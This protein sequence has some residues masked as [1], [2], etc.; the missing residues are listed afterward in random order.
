MMARVSHSGE[1]V[2]SM[3][4]CVVTPYFQPNPEWLARAHASVKA[5][6]IPAR[7]ILV[8]DG[9][10]PARIPDFL[11]T[12]IVLR[13]NYGDHGNTPRMI[14][15]FNA[16]T[17]ED[18][19]AIAFLD[20]ENWYYPD[21]LRYLLSIAQA[22]N[23]GAVSSARMLHR[24]DGTPIMKCPAVT[25]EQ[26]ADTNCMVVLRSAF[27]HL[28]AWVLGGPETAAEADQFCWRSLKSA[29]VP[30]AFVDR[31]TVAYRTRDPAHYG[32]LG[33]A[34]P[35]PMVS[36]GQATDPPGLARMETR[37]NLVASPAGRFASGEPTA[38]GTTASG[39]TVWPTPG[40][41]SQ[42]APAQSTPSLAT[43][44]MPTPA[45]TT[46]GM[47]TPASATPGRLEDVD[48]LSAAN[49]VFQLEAQRLL[50]PAGFRGGIEELRAA[51]VEPLFNLPALLPNS[52]W[53][54]HIPFL[55][56]LFRMLRPAIFVEL[57]VHTGASL[58]AAASAAAAYRVPTKLVGV[59][60]FIGDEHT[61]QYDGD[62]LYNGLRAYL[63][64][65]F[66]SVT[67]ERSYFAEALPRFPPASIDILHIDGLHTY[68][69]VREDFSTWFDRVSRHG[70]ILMHDIGVRDRGFGVHLLWDELKARML[71]LEFP[72]S[73][74]LG[75]I[76]LGPDDARFRPLVALVRDEQAMR[77]YRELVAEV[78]RL[79]PE[80][81]ATRT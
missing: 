80:R 8:G 72:H 68:E 33:A 52:A 31:P 14:G 7:H 3:K 32:E 60:T 5:Q 15:C 25:G 79:L 4:I 17:A 26:F 30:M 64:E 1:A 50:E 61:G 73:H 65:T 54:G 27:R 77:A 57:G 49:L 45:Q 24:L 42:A 66:P 48:R 75:V 22:A 46:P 23:L 41:P 34:P 16:I 20:A 53:S 2:G 44:G 6:S 11:G 36:P 38:A 29:G 81:M 78:A 69:A 62:G 59:D 12:H 71:T 35:S 9:T 10:E 39:I 28:I 74:G 76:L 40:T 47:P 56:A 63:A 51:L 13:R 18:A 43:P 70:V 19:D 55:F 37:E 21:H 67:L 58:I